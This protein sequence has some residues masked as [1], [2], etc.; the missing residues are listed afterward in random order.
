MASSIFYNGRLISVPGSYSEV[1][2][3]GLEAIGLG[4]AGIVAVLGT[5]E[6]GLPASAI[7]E[8]G[9][10]PRYTTPDQVRRA[11]RSGNLREA[12]GMLFEPS[13]DAE[14]QAGAQQMV[15]MK[16]NPAL[17]SS[18]T[19]A[20]TYG[21][22]LVVSSRDYGAFTGQIQVAIQDTD[23]PGAARQVTVTFEDTVESGA[24]VGGED[25]FSL[26]YRGNANAWETMTGQVLA[27][28]DLSCAGS[29]ADLGLDGDIANQLAAPG[30]VQV[31]SS[32]G[33]DTQTVEIWGLNGSGVPVKESLVLAGTTPVVGTQTFSK[34]YGARATGAAGSVTVDPSGGGSDVILMA[35]GVTKGI[36]LAQAMFVAGGVA[37][38]VADGASTKNVVLEGKSL[39]GAVQRE[40]LTLAGAVP[41]V[42]TATWS[43]ITL[44]I[45]GD[46]E[47]ART[48]TLS[49]VAAKALHAVQS[50]L[51]KA[52]DY[53]NARQVEISAVTYGFFMV[54]LTG[55]TTL[56][57]TD[58]DVS[59][60]AASIF[61]PIALAFK[62]D[63]Y[64]LLEWFNNS[65]QLVEA[66]KS[67]GASGG[68]PTNTTIPTFL[69]G[70]SEGTTL[71][72]HWQAALNWLKQIRVNTVVA[73]TPDP[74]VHAMVDAH[75][76][77]MCG[78]GRSERDAV[79]G[80][81]NAGMTGLATKAEI[82]SQIVDLNS[83]HI[84]A[85][86]QQIDRYNSLGERETFESYFQAL[87]AAGMQAGAPAVGTSLTH[88]YANALAVK[89]HS[90]WNPVVRSGYVVHG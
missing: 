37:T 82:K 78:I 61:Y 89:Q 18:A 38:V 56:V 62:A 74:A 49:A 3:S 4:A 8:V 33:A 66:T 59:P 65:S 81:M 11:F 84:R 42:G 31:V 17:Q 6:G 29:R 9:D 79:V 51:Q 75:C 80:L 30:A 57:V 39:T 69:S 2:A 14:I 55:Q 64:A 21:D 83:R 16:V 13:K 22:S 7:T 23:P 60:A 24:E 54:L 20:N 45:M 12:G 5:A 52:S 43:E 53:F 50:N 44:I 70:G 72:S 46:V 90:G 85:V 47:V 58:L 73:L 1:D 26:S 41:V 88:K 35:T 34:V 36:R 77:Y 48:V 40:K 76:A 67:S 15:A 27:N 19:F 10:I 28:G 71:A 63:L 87:L 32:N 68:F 25:M 86:A